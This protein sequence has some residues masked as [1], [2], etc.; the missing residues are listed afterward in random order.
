LFR[1]LTLAGVTPLTGTSSEQHMREDLA[2]FDLQLDTS[3]IERI[4]RLL[5]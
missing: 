2:I 5:E 1:Y 4:S 3:E